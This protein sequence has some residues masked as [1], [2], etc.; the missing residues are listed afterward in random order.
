[1]F[2]IGLVKHHHVH[3]DDVPLVHE[4]IAEEVEVLLFADLARRPRPLQN[5][6]ARR[7]DDRRVVG[8]G[9]DAPGLRGQ[10]ILDHGETPQAWD[11]HEKAAVRVGD[12]CRFQQRLVLAGEEMALKAM[13]SGWRLL[14]DDALEFVEVCL[15]HG[16]RSIEAEFDVPVAQIQLL[17]KL[18]QSPIRDRPFVG[19]Q[20]GSLSHHAQPLDDIRDVDRT[21][22]QSVPTQLSE[23]VDDRLHVFELGHVERARH[24]GLRLGMQPDAHLNDDAEIALEKETLDG[25]T[26]GKLGQVR[27]GGIG[28]RKLAGSE[29]I[30]V[31]KHDLQSADVLMMRRRRREACPTIESL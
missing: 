24:I 16:G 9:P 29:E 4:E 30:A 7:R 14:G 18:V 17:L 21:R 5:R 19:P 26:K 2:G 28:Y 12:G 27:G 10:A 13:G 6:L 11:A 8:M 20:F 22:E 3:K 25:R 23:Y 15:D 31:G 1:M